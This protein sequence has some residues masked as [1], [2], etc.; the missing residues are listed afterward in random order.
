MKS[1]RIA[2]GACALC[3]LSCG[4]SSGAGDADEAA[5]GGDTTVVNVTRDAFTQAAPNLTSEHDDQFFLGNAIFNRGWVTAP[6]SVTSFDGLGPLFNATNCS[7]CHLTDGRGHPPRTPE[8]PFTSMLLRLSVPGADP[9]GA[10][11]PEPTYGTQLQDNSVRNIRPEGVPH[12]TY[13][14]QPGTFPDGEPYSL[15][16]PTYSIDQLAYGPLAADVMISPRMAPAVFGLGLLEA[17]TEATLTEL[18]DPDDRDHD[19]IS[20]RINHVWNLKTQALAVG[21]FGWKANQPTIEQQTV[22]AFQGDM[23]ITSHGVPLQDCTRAEADCNAQPG[24]GDPDVELSDSILASVVDYSHTLAVPARRNVGDETV[25]RGQQVFASAGCAKCHIPK[26]K[27]GDL[28]DFPEVSQQTIRPYTDLLLHDMGP[29]LA[30]GRPDFEASGSEWRTPPLWG[31]GLSNVVNGYQFLL[32][33]GRARTVLE[34]VLFHGGE[35]SSSREAIRAAT[36]EDRAALVA[37]LGSL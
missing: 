19:G 16:V 1:G 8:E 29:E 18:A 33:D 13:S 35:A 9:T 25:R 6:A 12:V 34:A 26:L 27:T 32:H 3:L 20:G 24:G 30:D 28:P 31:I 36:R 21:R 17:I 4:G 14:E 7:A 37:F 5:S 15:R 11:A 2:L 23:G 10:P 22:S